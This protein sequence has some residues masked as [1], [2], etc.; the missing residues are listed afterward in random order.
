MKSRSID[1][2]SF[3]MG[4]LR[5]LHRTLE[6]LVLNI[7]IQKPELK[8][9]TVGLAEWQPRFLGS[10]FTSGKAHWIP[11]HG[12]II[13]NLH[14]LQHFTT[15]NFQE[16][17]PLPRLQKSSRPKFSEIEKPPG[18]FL[19]KS[20]AWHLCTM[21]MT[22]AKP[23]TCHLPSQNGRCHILGRQPTNQRRITLAVVHGLRQHASR[24]FWKPSSVFCDLSTCQGWTADW[25]GLAWSDR[26][27]ST[28]LDAAISSVGSTGWFMHVLQ[29]QTPG[30][31][32]QFPTSDQRFG[33]SCLLKGYFLQAI[34]SQFFYLARKNAKKS[35]RPMVRLGHWFTVVKIFLYF[36]WWFQ[37]FP[38]KGKSR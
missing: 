5:L 24:I 20:E 35:W 27:T 4:H 1:P 10:F 28:F 11:N 15:N 21:S 3:P 34:S 7:T 38:N 31:T 19:K 33:K 18:P 22:S 16:V 13:I 26:F 37:P 29:Q 6:L 23:V 32:R 8:Q 17:G 2:L 9:W 12:S 36:G 30:K 25:L 14:D